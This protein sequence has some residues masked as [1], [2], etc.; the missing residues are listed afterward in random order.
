[1]RC[2]VAPSPLALSGTGQLALASGPSPASRVL[3]PAATDTF[4]WHYT[5]T[6]VGEAR[7]TG[8]AAGTGATSGLF[9]RAPFATSGLQKI[10]TGT[11]LL[12][13]TPVQTM[14]VRFS[15]WVMHASVLPDEIYLTL[16]PQSYTPESGL[17]KPDPSPAVMPGENP[18]ELT[19]Y[20]PQ[21]FQTKK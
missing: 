9:R 6:A 2:R 16:L 20:G 12:A 15:T 13:M 10:L 3:A 8:N 14:P 7:L 18:T 4:V 1:M 5:A 19:P 11:N 21:G 17:T